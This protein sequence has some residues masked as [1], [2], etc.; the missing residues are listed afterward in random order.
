MGTLVCA[1]LRNMINASVKSLADRSKIWYGK[2]DMA[3][4]E[5]G[6][7]GT[8]G[9]A[10]GQLMR[11]ESSGGGD[12]ENV[13]RDSQAGAQR[14]GDD[15]QTLQNKKGWHAKNW[16]R[17]SNNQTQGQQLLRRGSDRKM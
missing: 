14:T 13:R 7:G 4:T 1:K 2:R 3:G 9:D 10:T 5:R 15:S 12:L 17:T 6:S 11:R 16:R 8:V